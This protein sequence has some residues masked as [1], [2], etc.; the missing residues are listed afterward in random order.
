MRPLIDNMYRR[1][2]PLPYPT[3]ADTPPSGLPPAANALNSQLA[4]SLLQDVAAQ[5]ASTSGTRSAPAPTSGSGSSSSSHLHIST[6]LASF[7][8]VIRD[9]RAAVVLFVSSSADNGGVERVFERL[10]R[11]K[12]RKNAVAFVK[13]DK[14]AG[15]GA[16]VL[17]KCG[18]DA[19]PSFQFY[20]KGE[21]VKEEFA[22][23]G[24]ATSLLLTRQCCIG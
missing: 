20:R 16:E 11:D 19:T 15:N 7:E 6:N 14:E 5:A 8:N 9:H 17:T 10:A 2:G 12:A 18:I 21:K 13:V 22:H 1:S 23:T 4:T 24:T 3:P